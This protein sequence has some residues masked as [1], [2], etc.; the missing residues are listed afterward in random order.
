MKKKSAFE[1]EEICDIVTPVTRC[2]SRARRTR[3]EG[4]EGSFANPRCPSAGMVIRVSNDVLVVPP[5]DCAWLSSPDA[6]SLTTASSEGGEGIVVSFDAKADSDVTVILKGRRTS[7]SELDSR[8]ARRLDH[9]SGRQ[10]DPAKVDA[11]TYLVIIGSHRN[12]ACVIEKNGRVVELA[13]G[14]AVPLLPA[15]GRDA[16]TRCFVSWY[17]KRGALVVG[18]GEHLR[19]AWVDP[20]PHTDPICEIGLSTW[21]DHAQYRDIEVRA[22]DPDGGSRVSSWSA[23]PADSPRGGRRPPPPPAGVENLRG[24]S[25]RRNL[26]TGNLTTESNN[27]VAP[28]ASL[29]V[30]CVET[31]A[32]NLPAVARA[33]PA[34]MARITPE[35]LVAVLTHDALGDSVASEDEVW[36]HVREWCVGRRGDEVREVLP[37]VR[38]PTLATETLDQCE[39]WAVRVGMDADGV[40]ALRELVAEARAWRIPEGLGS[41]YAKR[42]HEDD[43][44]DEAGLAA[45]AAVGLT[46]VTEAMDDTDED[47]SPGRRERGGRSPL[48]RTARMRVSP[49]GS[50][51]C[52]AS[53]ANASGAGDGSRDRRLRARLVELAATRRSPRR[54]HGAVLSFLCAGDGNGLF[55]YLGGGGSGGGGGGGGRGGDFFNPARSGAVDVTASSPASRGGTSPTDVASVTFNRTNFAGPARNPRTGE[56]EGGWWRVDLGPNKSL[57]CDYYAARRNGELEGQPRCFVLEG[58]ADGENWWTLRRH[59]DDDALA[60]PGVWGAW[61]VPPPGSGRSCRYL[62]VRLTEN[63]G[64]D[65]EVSG[66]RLRLSNLEFYGVLSTRKS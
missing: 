27:A 6:D 60:T 40:G 19:H 52:I 51:V 10:D 45:A 31:I 35:H 63:T 14:P 9:W 3:R 25:P 49:H 23:T 65:G 32:R 30:R 16:F 56:T 46:E 50:S 41:E 26:T 59:S 53:C 42:E 55:R 7:K 2:R 4:P 54:G 33:E 58:S 34:G 24:L 29:L 8:P 11:S 36:G 1:R 39:E 28:S 61:P 43:E 64:I 62:R 13:K 44:D 47:G 37:H 12:S 17:P 21:D 48:S 66:W 18:V 15:R 20:E 57:R 38:F 22:L 5:F